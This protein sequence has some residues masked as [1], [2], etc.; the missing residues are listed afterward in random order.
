MNTTTR[1]TYWIAKTEEEKTL[2]EMI[3]NT[4]SA[5]GLS[6]WTVIF[7]RETNRLGYCKYQAKE[8]CISRKVILTSWEEAVD[9][10]MHEVAH[11]VVGLQVTLREGGHG[12]S[13]QA[14]ASQLGALPRAKADGYVSLHQTGEKKI[15]KTSYGPVEVE[16][17]KTAIV[18]ASIGELKII[19]IQRKYFI[20][21]SALGSLHRLSVDIL[22]PDFGNSEKI[23]ERDVTINDRRGRPIKVTLGKT[24]Y[25]YQGETYVAIEPRRRTV[26]MLSPS[27]KRLNV[28]VE[29]FR[30]GGIR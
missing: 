29:F 27:G 9:T 6:G 26:L 11:A 24:T 22:H 4:L 12:P 13:W 28:D 23:P 5:Q 18:H 17:G 21:K 3:L 8:I 25:S 10:A 14:M 7:S 16:I 19:E 15:A 1:G 30:N 20:G 2:Q